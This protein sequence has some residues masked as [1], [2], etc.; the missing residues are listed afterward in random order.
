MSCLA[1][2]LLFLLLSLLACPALSDP[3][4]QSCGTT[5]NYTTNS[6]Y[7]SNLL[8]LLSSLYSNGSISGFYKNTVGTVPND[9]I[10]GLVLCRGDINTTTCRNCLEVAMQDVL[11]ICSNKKGALV[12]YDLC[13]LGYSNQNFLSSTND[14]NPLIMYNAQNLS[15]PEKFNRLEVDL[16]VMDMIARSAANS[17]RRFAT[18][19]TPVTVSYHKI[20]GLGQCTPDLS[21]DQCYLCLKG[22]FKVI[23]DF[24][25]SRGLRVIGVRCNFRFELYQFYQYEEPL[26]PLSAP[27]PRSNDTNTTT[28]T[29]TT[30]EEGEG[31][32]G[33]V[34][35][36]ALKDGQEIAVKR[37]SRT[38]EQGLLELRNEV[39]FVAKL[40]HR[41][42][43]RLLGCCLEEKEKLLVYE[44]L[45]N[46]SLDKI[47]FDPLRSQSLEW[48]LRY[49]II[50]GISRGLFYLHEDSRL[51][52]IHRDLKA[53]NVLLDKDM[54]P[55]ISDF[56]LAKHFG[57]NET[58]KDTGRIAGTH[59]YM[60]PEYAI[61]GR[62]SP[63]SDVFSYGVLALEIVTGGKN[64]D[65]EK[66]NPPT[67]LLTH[68][69]RQW[70]EGNPLELVDQTLG[71]IFI[72][73]QVLRCIHIGLLCVQEDPTKR[74][75][76]ASV[77]NMLNNDS[78]SLPIS[79]APAFFISPDE[80]LDFVI[81]E[82]AN[83]YNHA[84][85]ISEN[86][87]SISEIGPR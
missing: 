46:R 81:E 59:G 5:G 69:W 82:D 53:S 51:K 48:C 2:T 24:V 17:S 34:Y 74:P 45:P 26:L 71:N 56:G 32:F 16:I 83:G 4:Y 65:F 66:C 27:S 38:S 7:Q 72:K 15:D 18:W 43:V 41:N 33:Q 9:K 79:T 30:A 76:M 22:V 75:S 10:Y 73:E 70:N 11:Q 52:I 29:T 87:V 31:G 86:E 55:K 68:V 6:T 47:L 57:A 39:V 63:K 60:A 40:Q 1:E 3:L 54:N 64:S 49:K 80:V 20:Y 21:G 36:G 12:W 78:V 44:Y 25:Y 14:S 50:E 35:K 23:P 77:V 85:M 37:L 19:E 13:L 28:T 42:L 84:Q 67:N 8:T 62:L 58:H 61:Y